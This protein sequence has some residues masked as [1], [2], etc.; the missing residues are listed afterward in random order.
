M[1]AASNC[2]PSKARAD[3]A[4]NARAWKCLPACESTADQSSSSPGCARDQ[5]PRRRGALGGSAA[6]PGSWSC[7]C[8]ARHR[9]TAGGFADAPRRERFMLT[10]IKPHRRN[11]AN[12][13]RVAIER[14]GTCWWPVGLRTNS[15]ARSTPACAQGPRIALGFNDCQAEDA[16][17]IAASTMVCAC[18]RTRC[19][20]SRPMKLSA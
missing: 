14:R 18:C 4:V 13:G 19:K 11:G 3:T 10:L 1:K 9:A 17:R 7:C 6:G 8:V 15:S 20:C 2:S 12:N 5:T 16:G